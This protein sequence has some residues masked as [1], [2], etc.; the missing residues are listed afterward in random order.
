M[1]SFWGNHM[2]WWMNI[3]NP[4][5]HLESPVYQLQ[6]SFVEVVQPVEMLKGLATSVWDNSTTIPP[7]LPPTIPAFALLFMTQN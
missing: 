2:H 4:A 6:T 3:L 1:Q 7:N 5:F